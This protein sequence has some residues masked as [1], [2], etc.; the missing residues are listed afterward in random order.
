MLIP[1]LQLIEKTLTSDVSIYGEKRA[2][3]FQDYL[4]G[5][6]QIILVKVGHK[7]DDVTAGNIVKLLV[8]IF[9]ALKRVTENG[10]IAF[11]G[12]ING[13]GD[14]VNVN[15]FGQ[16]IVWALQGND[17]ECIRLACGI[18]SDLAGA[19]HEGI[20]RYL[21]DFVPHL[22]KIL[23]DQN[24]DRRSKLQAIVAL[25]DLAMNSG[26]TFSHQYLS[27]VLKILESASAQC[28]TVSNSDDD[29]ELTQYLI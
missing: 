5:L 19:L 21:G 9:Q 1:V 23:R 24:Q 28:L 12:L 16:Y 27:D 10:L 8:M 20:S 18:V 15:E 22:L 6:L 14:R 29:A 17:D 13:V 7:L 11:S 4:G 3:D 26:E 2:K 25:G